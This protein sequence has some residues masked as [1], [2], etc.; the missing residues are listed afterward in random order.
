MKESK[1][2]RTRDKIIRL[3]I[4]AISGSV[5]F[6][7]PYLRYLYYDTLL[8]AVGLSNAQFGMT[9][10]VFGIVSML[11]YFPGGAIADRF[12]AKKLITF[13][14]LG[15]AATAIWFSFFPGYAIQLVIY[16]LWAVFISLTFW[17]AMNKAIRVTG[18]SEEQG[19]LFGLVEGGRGLFPM[20]YG[21]VVL[22]IFNHLGANVFGLTWAIRTYAALSVIGA[23][24][25]W[26]FL[27][28]V[29][30]EAGT[31]QVQKSGNGVKNMI[32]VLKYPSV[33]M[34]SIIIFSSFVAYAGQS[35]VTPYLSEIFGAS[36]SLAAAL[37]LVR[38]YGLA[39][40]GGPLGGVFADK[41]KSTTK[42][43]AVCFV[44][45]GMALVAFMLVPPSPE[46]L[47]VVTVAMVIMGFFVFATRGIYFATI[48]EACIPIELTG[49]AVGFAS[50]IGFI[51]D[52][53]I[54]TLFGTWMDQHPGIEGYRMIFGFMLLFAVLGFIASILL[55]RF[56]KKQKVKENE[57]G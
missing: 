31:E 19:R 55:I 52:A 48:D 39:I 43:L 34:V 36:A 44:F 8:E 51:P 11:T 20:L 57:N 14:L 3:I 21:F 41:V 17:A 26:L 1:H 42:V 5:I 7:V 35:Y 22:A 2:F 29:K 33:W 27:E 53:F 13:S 16:S 30:E 47:I 38:T 4:I 25:V 50:F 49:S 54:Y 12:S 10:S 40:G 45:I 6:E 24:L 32:A 37:G 18:S 56:V 23:V 46:L 28:D 15:V 9:M